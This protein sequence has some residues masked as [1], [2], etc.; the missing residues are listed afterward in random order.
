MYTLFEQIILHR[1]VFA[2]CRHAFA[3]ASRA[4]AF[5]IALS[6]T[7]M[8]SHATHPRA[9]QRFRAPLGAV[10]PRAFFSCTFCG[11]VLSIFH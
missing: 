9:L 10:H 6:C 5:C 2:F 11:G 1:C 8:C 7:A 4:F 3:S